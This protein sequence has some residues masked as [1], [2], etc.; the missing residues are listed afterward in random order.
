MQPCGMVMVCFQVNQRVAM[1]GQNTASTG[2]CS[3]PRSIPDHYQAQAQTCGNCG[4]ESVCHKQCTGCSCTVCDHCMAKGDDCCVQCVDMYEVKHQCG[5]CAST[6][7]S[8]KKCYSCATMVCSQCMVSEEEGC[9]PCL[10]DFA[11]SPGFGK[12][13][14]ATIVDCN[15]GS[16][17]MLPPRCEP[18]EVPSSRASSTGAGSS[19]VCTL[20]C[21]KSWAD[22]SDAESTHL[23]E[24]SEV[25]VVSK[26][27]T[28][29]MICNV[30]CS[31][32]QQAVMEA[33][34]SVGFA[35]AYNFVY[36]PVRLW[37]RN[38]TKFTGNLGYAFVDFKHAD[39]A[40]RFAIAFEDYKFAGTHST[41]RCT[42][43]HAREQGFNASQAAA[44]QSA[45]GKP[46]RSTLALVDL[47]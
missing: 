27:A 45:N 5:N 12:V 2:A 9:L 29:M 32:N 31:V 44:N 22:E 19:S 43:K 16:S 46:A 36:L 20:R 8:V 41:K 40:E 23:D 24:E 42:V 47:I 14:Q 35:G 10:H 7:Q 17:L 15:Q 25:S 18:P 4:M 6:C 38:R 26:E 13:P 37:R 39:D 30:P 11:V 3:Q 1:P 28:T 34:D 33:I 21:G